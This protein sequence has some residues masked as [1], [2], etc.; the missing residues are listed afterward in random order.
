MR[1]CIETNGR[2]KNMDSWKNLEN[3]AYGW[4]KVIIDFPSRCQNQT[5]HTDVSGPKASVATLG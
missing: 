4:N 1:M 2:R 3:T 5:S